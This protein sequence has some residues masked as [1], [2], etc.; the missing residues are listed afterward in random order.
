M[1][2]PLEVV[3]VILCKLS[4]EDALFSPDIVAIKT[5]IKL[6]PIEWQ[7][8]LSKYTKVTTSKITD[9]IHLSEI[10]S[11]LHP[12]DVAM[13]QNEYVKRRQD[14]QKK[15]KRGMPETFALKVVRSIL[16]QKYGSA[17]NWRFQQI[18]YVSERNNI[19][20]WTKELIQ[21]LMSR[22]LTHLC[23]QSIKFK[24]SR[25]ILKMIELTKYLK[26]LQAHLYR[27]EV[28]DLIFEYMINDLYL[29]HPEI[30]IIHIE[31]GVIAANKELWTMYSERLMEYFVGSSQELARFN[32]TLFEVGKKTNWNYKQLQLIT[33]EEL[34]ISID[35][36][37]II[38][39]VLVNN[40]EVSTFKSIVGDAQDDL[41]WE[42]ADAKRLELQLNPEDESDALAMFSDYVLEECIEDKAIERYI[43]L[44]QDFISIKHTFAANNIIID[45]QGKKILCQSVSLE[46]I[47]SLDIWDDFVEMWEK[48]EFDAD[49]YINIF[50]RY[51]E[52]KNALEDK[53][54]ELRED[55]ES[56][57]KYIEEDEGCVK[58]I[59]CTMQEMNFYFSQTDYEEI[60][61]NIRH[62]RN[63]YFMSRYAESLWA[64][65]VAMYYY[66]ADEGI[67][68]D[69]VDTTKFEEDD[70]IHQVEKY[71]TLLKTP[72][73]FGLNCQDEYDSSSSDY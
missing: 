13:I 49:D 63:Y 38:C 65:K 57:R 24:I 21:T 58:D 50:N 52:L 66:I 2:F 30:L 67:V 61:N 54:L 23:S 46:D 53:N 55:S 60:V 25:I 56:C 32:N 14:N 37:S 12:D 28:I 8:H 26:V 33:H 36:L 51:F 7:S 42:V 16:L 4:Q 20:I 11:R 31:N 19:K 72:E 69:F 44:I 62:H 48:A 27:A 1:I 40:V 71:E 59:V 22:V 29:D 18:Q 41:F 47:V 34:Y 10:K 35:Q 17:W 5:I 9:V 45:I 70:I 6:C 68:P 64:K 73:C 15:K 39:D 43:G 3:D